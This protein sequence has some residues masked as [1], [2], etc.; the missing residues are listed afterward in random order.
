M[1]DAQE[2]LSEVDGITPEYLNDHR[3]VVV[4]SMLSQ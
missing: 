1:V 3:E 4:V 2:Y